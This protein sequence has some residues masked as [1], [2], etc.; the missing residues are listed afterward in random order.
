MDG[1]KLMNYRGLV[2]K[3]EGGERRETVLVQRTEALPSH[4]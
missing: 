1:A 2:G 3:L 4:M